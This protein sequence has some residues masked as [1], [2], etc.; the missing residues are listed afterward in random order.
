MSG[1]KEPGLF[2]LVTVNGPLL[3]R[4]SYTQRYVCRDSS[5]NWVPFFSKI[6]DRTL[7]TVQIWHSQTPS[8][9]LADGTFI[10]NLIQS[11]LLPWSLQSLQTG[12]LQHIEWWSALIKD[13]LSRKLALSRCTALDAIQVNNI[14]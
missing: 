5:S 10:F 12:S 1:S 14:E 4:A 2:K 6:A 7:H 8:K 3:I 13:D 11:Q 9:W